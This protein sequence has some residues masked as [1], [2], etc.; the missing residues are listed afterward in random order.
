MALKIDW[1]AA[2][3]RL[4]EITRSLDVQ[5]QLSPE[6]ARE[7]MA[8]R[9]KLLGR[10]PSSADLAQRVDL[11][12]FACGGERFALQTRFI[13]ATLRLP[14]V[15]A[16]PFSPAAL[17]GLCAFRGQLLS[18]WDPAELLTGAASALTPGW[19]L[20][21][22]ESRAEVGLAVQEVS[23]VQQ[24]PTGD[25]VPMPEALSVP[26]RSH[27]FEGLI[28]EESIRVLSGEAILAEPRLAW[29]S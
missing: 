2:K 11:V 13:R 25:V 19:L 12:R 17:L 4:V 10:S 26:T 22:G 5:T 7:V 29:S 8:E 9:A 21:V 14:K 6:R 16:V 28:A 23:F 3:A 1:E 20:V 24:T 15:S 18:V 27:L